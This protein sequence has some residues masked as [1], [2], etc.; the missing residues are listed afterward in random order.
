MISFGVDLGNKITARLLGLSNFHK[1]ELWKPI[2]FYRKKSSYQ[3]TLIYIEI[4][5]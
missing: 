2:A 1:A 5:D 3:L 4:N